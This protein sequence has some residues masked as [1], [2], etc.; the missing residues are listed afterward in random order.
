MRGAFTVNV[1]IGTGS[2]G[3]FQEDRRVEIRVPVETLDRALAQAGVAAKDVKLIWMDIQGFEGKCLEGAEQTLAAGMPVI[4]EFW[5]YGIARS[6]T[7]RAEYM[8][9]LGRHFDRA[10]RILDDA[11]VSLAIAEVDALFDEVR[12]PNKMA[13]LL[14]VKERT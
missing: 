8:G 7:T 13:Q 11:V 4:T 6:G 5:P 3:A 10:Y 1:T 14:F 12:Q 9:V 2:P